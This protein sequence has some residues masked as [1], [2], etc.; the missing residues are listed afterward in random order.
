MKI[1]IIGTGIYGIALALDM[2]SNG[3][4]VI[5][6]TES[7]KL[8]KRYLEKHDFKPITDAFI[9]DE[10]KVTTDIKEALENTDFIVL[11][12]SAKYVRSICKDMKKHYNTLTPICIASNSICFSL[13]YF[14]LLKI[15]Y[16]TS[17]WVSILFFF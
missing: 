11:A 13:I 1:S 2:V 10:I 6:W 14:Y 17:V 7:D 4:S 8:Y 16:N 15:L 5:T 3:H 12:T 9:P